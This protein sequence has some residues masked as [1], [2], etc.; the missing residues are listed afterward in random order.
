M[1]ESEADNPVQDVVLYHEHHIENHGKV[2]Q[3]QLRGIP[4]HRAPVVEPPSIKY[5]L[6]DA[7][8]PPK[9][10]E[11]NIMYAPTV[12][13]LALV[14]HPDLRQVFREGDR[15]LD[16]R[17]GQQVREPRRV[18]L[19]SRLDCRSK[20]NAEDRKARD[21]GHYGIAQDPLSPRQRRMIVERPN[22][23]QRDQ[24]DQRGVTS[25]EHVVQPYRVLVAV[26]SVC[27]LLPHRSVPTQR[28]VECEVAREAQQVQQLVFNRQAH[29][30]S[31]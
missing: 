28:G 12:R 7:Q 9:E 4:S 3:Q 20:A 10:V 11:D 23:E 21:G 5:Q 25:E 17:H 16:V 27:V 24:G 2:S 19:R 26:V 31:P 8:E 13:A 14:I 6:K 15:H 29:H 18:P 30:A 1:A 22:L